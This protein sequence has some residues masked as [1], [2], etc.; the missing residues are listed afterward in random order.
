MREISLMQLRG[1]IPAELLCMLN[2]INRIDNEFLGIEDDKEPLNWR[3]TLDLVMYHRVYPHVFHSISKNK[4]DFQPPKEFVQSISTKYSQNTFK[5][6]RLSA[7]L[8]R[9]SKEFKESD[10]P[11]I[12][13]K[14]P[15]IAVKL[16]N[17][18]SLRPAKDLDLL[19]PP[20]KLKEAEKLLVKNGYQPVDEFA[21]FENLH[22][23]KSQHKVYK[24]PDNGILIELHWKLHP[25][26]YTEPSFQEL[27]DRKERVTIAGTDV[28]TLGTIDLCLF[29][30]THGSRHSWFRLRWL[31]DFHLLL[32]EPL[33]FEEI[34]NQA[35]NL[36]IE[37]MVG[38]AVL[39]SNRLFNSPIPNE[40]VRFTNTTT[41]RKLTK[42]SLQ[43]II[44]N[45]DITNPPLP[46][47]DY[48]LMKRYS[49]SLRGERKQKMKFL[50]Q[51][52][53]PNQNDFETIKLPKSLY[54]LYYP[55]RPF[56][57]MVRRLKKIS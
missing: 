47:K 9:V 14:G 19:V 4:T 37:H 44:N 31:Y 51:H 26:V 18:L 29:L 38:Q 45:K 27:W 33:D 43:I 52:F 39:L 6:L 13:L 35:R 57:W 46:M 24:N 28:H 15:V 12:C 1:E 5:M 42:M 50:G 23:K 40:L 53:Y 3:K 21:P 8:A 17:D 30:A 56:L 54:G 25:N 34:A 41:C 20:S 10:I 32:Q 22:L 2:Y 16:Y 11:L 49:L 48:L 55:L 7:E 36:H